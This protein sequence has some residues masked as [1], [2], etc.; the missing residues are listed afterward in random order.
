M[1]TVLGGH[2][3]VPIACDNPAGGSLKH[4]QRQHLRTLFWICYVFDK[5]I[6]L[7]TSHPPSLTE[8]Y[9]DLTS[10]NNDIINS[11]DNVRNEAKPLKLHG[12][13]GLSHLKGKA[14]HLLYSIQASRQSNAELLR[15][16]RELDA[17]LEEW[18]LS[19]PPEERPSLLMSY[20]SRSPNYKAQPPCTMRVILIHLEYFYLLIAIHH[21][22][23][24]CTIPISQNGYPEEFSPSVLKT[25]L[26]IALEAS[27]SILIYLTATASHLAAETFW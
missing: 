17:E 12:D 22:S 21:A 9:C 19:L 23:G 5:E 24:R 14:S 1:I 2:I 20:A 6:T 15:N 26:A 11:A 4:R 16:I 25:S 8:P 3:D 7:R 18:R 27:R 13:I 10:P